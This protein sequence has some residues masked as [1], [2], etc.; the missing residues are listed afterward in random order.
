LLA[1]TLGGVQ[2]TATL[3][4][5]PD[6]PTDDS[7]FAL[8]ESLA[9]SGDET[10]VYAKAEKHDSNTISA[11]VTAMEAFIDLALLKKLPILFNFSFLLYKFLSGI[12]PHY[13]VKD[14]LVI[15]IVKNTSMHAKSFSGS[16]FTAARSL[17]VGLR[18]FLTYRYLE[19]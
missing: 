4:G 3:A 13:A 2:V 8:A 6:V 17:C 18:R 7:V 16:T 1:K 19:G 11:R 15:R 12:Q 14:D 10:R 5:T 9:L